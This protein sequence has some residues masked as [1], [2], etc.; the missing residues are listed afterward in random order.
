QHHAGAATLNQTHHVW[1]GLNAWSLFSHGDRHTVV[2][3]SLFQNI[4]CIKYK[5][6][7]HK[8][9]SVM[10]TGTDFNGGSGNIPL[11]TLYLSSYVNKTMYGF[12]MEGSQDTFDRYLPTFQIMLSSFKAPAA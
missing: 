11:A 8:A 12:V 9:C 6:D 5:I 4:E 1:C 7:G 10:W 2:G 3:S